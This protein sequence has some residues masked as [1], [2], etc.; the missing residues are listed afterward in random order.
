MTYKINIVR[1]KLSDGSEVLSIKLV[2]QDGAYLV[3]DMVS[4]DDAIIFSEG[5][6]DIINFCCVEGSELHK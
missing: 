3:F 1:D 2:D 4:E 5:L 6:R